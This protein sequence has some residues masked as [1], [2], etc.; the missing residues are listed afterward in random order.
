MRS[1]FALRQRLFVRLG[2]VTQTVTHP[3]CVTAVTAVANLAV[4]GHRRSPGTGK[5]PLKSAGGNE[6]A[7]AFGMRVTNW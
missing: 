4:L 6:M 5:R 2:F 3:P 1:E 7:E